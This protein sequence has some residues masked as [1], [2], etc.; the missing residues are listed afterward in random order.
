[1]AVEGRVGVDAVDQRE[2]LVLRRGLG[3]D[4]GDGVH[5]RLLAGLPLHPDVDVAGRVVPDQDHRQPG[6]EPVPPQRLHLL[7]HLGADHRADG[8]AVDDARGHRA[9]P[10]ARVS[11]MTTTLIWP[12]YW[13]SS[14]MRRAMSSESSVARPS[15][16]RSGVTITRTSRPA[17]MTLAFSTPSNPLAISSSLVS[18]LTWVSNASRLA[19][20]REPLMP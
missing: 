10:T 3:E 15:S 12:G 16:T 14:S 9:I 1:E 8:L 20:G 19:P 5:P 11:R 2:E 17:W 13:S 7:G 18:R 6:D 4:V